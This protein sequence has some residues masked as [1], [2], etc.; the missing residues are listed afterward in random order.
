[1]N[2]LF[3]ILPIIIRPVN[4]PLFF[5]FEASGCRSYFLLTALILYNKVNTF[6]PLAKPQHLQGDSDLLDIDVYASVLVLRNPLYDVLNNGCYKNVVKVHTFLRHYFENGKLDY[7]TNPY[8]SIDVDYQGNNADSLKHLSLSAFSTICPIWLY[9][10][11]TAN[12]TDRKILTSQ[13]FHFKTRCLTFPLVHQSLWNLH[14][15]DLWLLLNDI[16]VKILYWDRRLNFLFVNIPFNCLANVMI[17]TLTYIHIRA[18]LFIQNLSKL[19]I[20]FGVIIS[21]QEISNQCLHSTVYQVF[22]LYDWDCEPHVIKL[23]S[24]NDD[25]SRRDMEEKICKIW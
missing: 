22:I 12:E 21:G 7:C 24:K 10:K 17:T 14:G 6:Y 5:F 13:A 25:V 2:N 4:D 15:R 18:H 19:K 16:Y 9:Q 23:Y 20:I 1:M 8:F 3:D 11:L